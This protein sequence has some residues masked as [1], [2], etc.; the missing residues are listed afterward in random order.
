MNLGE[1]SQAQDELMVQATW[2]LVHF[3]YDNYGNEIFGDNLF[4]L[5]IF[6]EICVKFMHSLFMLY[7]SWKNTLRNRFKKMFLLFADF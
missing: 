2:F 1:S 5:F 4:C 3:L 6:V 7:Y